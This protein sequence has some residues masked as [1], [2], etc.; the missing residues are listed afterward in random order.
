MIDTDK[1]EGQDYHW[2]LKYYKNTGKHEV[3]VEGK[4]EVEDSH[5]CYL[6][7]H[8]S[9]KDEQARNAKLIADAPLLLAEVKRLHKQLV[10]YTDFVLWVEEYHNEVFDEYERKDE[11]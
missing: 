7:Y 4:N 9:C 11:L 3:R 5:V 8:P 6:Q 10:A 2:C 1:Y